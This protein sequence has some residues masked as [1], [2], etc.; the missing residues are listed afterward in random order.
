M[1][2][3]CVT[4]SELCLTCWILAELGS[5]GVARLGWRLIVKLY[6]NRFSN[7][8]T[9]ERKVVGDISDH[10]IPVFGWFLL[11][12]H[13]ILVCCI[14]LYQLVY[15][16]CLIVL[17]LF[18]YVCKYVLILNLLEQWCAGLSHPRSPLFFGN[19]TSVPMQWLLREYPDKYGISDLWCKIH[20]SKECCGAALYIPMWTTCEDLFLLTIFH[21]F[22]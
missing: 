14:D 17:F 3:P 6:H 7:H 10:W 18:R 11:L 1:L 4:C 5:L 21:D 2:L 20:T 16:I 12:W 8:C 9:L 22:L 19:M 13:C 15:A